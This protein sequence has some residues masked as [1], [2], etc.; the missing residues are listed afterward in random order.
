MEKSHESFDELFDLLASIKDD[1]VNEAIQ[2]V[3]RYRAGLIP[4]ASQ[5]RDRLPNIV[6]KLQGEQDRSWLEAVLCVR[7]QQMGRDKAWRRF[8]QD[9][10]RE[11]L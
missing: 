10:Y 6:S 7:A 8:A 9:A 4:T 2:L 1:E 11:M 5:P 3:R